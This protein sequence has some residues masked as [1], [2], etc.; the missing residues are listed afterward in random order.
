MKQ[1][2][3]YTLDQYLA[4]NKEQWD[5]LSSKQVVDF[6]KKRQEYMKNNPVIARAKSISLTAEQRFDARAGRL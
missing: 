6:C 1:T 2:V 3:E 5:A 4:M